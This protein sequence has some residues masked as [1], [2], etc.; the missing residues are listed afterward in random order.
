MMSC[1]AGILIRIGIRI[2]ALIRILLLVLLIGGGFWLLHTM[3]IQLRQ[4]PQGTPGPRPGSVE[5]PDGT[6]TFRLDYA[7]FRAEFPQLQRYRCRELIPGDGVCTGPP[8][9]PLLLLA[10]KSHPASS[11]RRAT[12]H[13]TWA[14]P[15]VLGGY[16]VRAVFLVGV[17]P[18]PRDLAL[19]EEEI[20]EFGDVVLWDFA[21][22]HQNLSL[23]ERCFLR[24]VGARCRQ[25]DFIFKG[26]DDEFV[27]PPALVTYLGQTPNASHVIHGNIQRHAVVF[28]GG[29]YRVSS[30]LFPQDM[31]PD[32]PSGG[33]FLM[34]RA[35][36]PVLAAAS[37]RIPVFP[38][39]DVYFGFLVLAAGL[40]YRHD[41]RFQVFG[42]KDEL[43]LYMEAVVVHGVSLDRTAP[44]P[45]HSAA[46]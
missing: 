25:A 11:A 31:Y 5:L 18:D 36:V 21:E 19:L 27:N 33:G 22:S 37:E 26:D 17:S 12:A 13:R 3:R 43:C 34:P 32:F 7:A 20:Q 45:I 6:F 46:P 14:R 4:T 30:A 15:R 8:G 9:P 16:R 24:W 39:D 35:S 44:T 40:R 28:R 42:M 10:V 2:L 23:K 41:E 1:N 38:L 29:K